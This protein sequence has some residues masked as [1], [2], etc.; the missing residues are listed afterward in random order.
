MLEYITKTV[1]SETV[2]TSVFKESKTMTRKVFTKF[3]KLCSK[4]IFVYKDDV[5]KQK[6]GVAMGSPLALL[7]ANWFVSKN[8]NTIFNQDHTCKLVFYAR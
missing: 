4:G 7:L 1:Y 6:D 3:L 2:P 8:E 5:Y